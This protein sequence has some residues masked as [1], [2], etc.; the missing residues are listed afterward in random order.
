MRP[1][2]SGGACTGVL[3]AAS[4]L[5][6]DQ[7]TKVVAVHDGT[8]HVWRNPGYAFGIVGGSATMLIAGAVGVLGAFL[9]VAR[10][11]AS[12]FGISILLPA[13]VAGGA[14]GNTLR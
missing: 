10:T 9:I 6:I 11:L 8:R 5:L 13:L 7:L 4:V 1:N 12:R 2:R 14:L 3:V